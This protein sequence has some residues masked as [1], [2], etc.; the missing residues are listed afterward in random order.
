[1]RE[2]PI[3]LS[4]PHGGTRIPEELKQLV[5]ISG[6]DLF[7]DIDPYTREIYDLGT[8][9]V[10]VVKADIARAFVDLNRAKNDLPPH[11]PDGVIKTKT[12]YGK[13]IYNQESLDHRLIYHL[14]KEYYEPYHQQIQNRLI[15]TDIELALDCH[16]M[17]PVGPQ[18]APDT[19]KKRPLICLGNVHG[20]SCSNETVERLAECVRKA[21]SLDSE[22]VTINSPFSGGYIARTYGNNPIPWIQ[23]ELNRAL[24]LDPK[25]F[26]RKY[27]RM[28][29]GRLKELNQMFEIALKQFFNAFD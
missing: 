13:P 23:V 28:A 29:K 22:E 10:D 9:V 14:I 5:C 21:F 25:W 11:N 20:Q 7:D 17:A 2:I 3:I 26:N 8:K 4:I 1:M 19:G 12:C 27:I 18:I 16:S 6:I 15:Q 24:Y